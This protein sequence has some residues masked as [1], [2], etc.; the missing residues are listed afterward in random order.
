MPRALAVTWDLVK[1]DLPDD[2]KKATA[3]VFDQVLGLRLTEWAPEEEALPDAVVALANQR[4]Q[5]RVEKRYADADTL[6]DQIIAAGYE[7]KDTPTGPEVTR[8]PKAD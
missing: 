1:S 6:R 3:A 2:V 5:A 8:K 7:I 4:Q